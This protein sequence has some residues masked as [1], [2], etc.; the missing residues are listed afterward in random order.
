MR[1]AL[2]TVGVDAHQ[3]DAMAED[4]HQRFIR[5]A[6]RRTNRV[7][8]ALRILGNCSNR[9]AY[10]YDE[11]ELDKIFREI[12]AQVKDTRALFRAGARRRFSL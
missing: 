4:R 1:R 6:E 2:G 12:D 10:E 8:E 7:L 3:E 9:S 5:I 11:Q